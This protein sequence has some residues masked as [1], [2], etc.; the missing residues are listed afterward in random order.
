[1]KRRP[2]GLRDKN[3]VEQPLE[4]T[5]VLA[6]GATAAKT[7]STLSRP[8]YFVPVAKEELDRAAEATG[9][10]ST[11]LQTLTLTAAL[12]LIAAGIWWF[13]QPPTAESL[14]RR[15]S[16]RT[17][18]KAIG[19]LRDA[20]GDIREYLDR[21]PNDAH[22]KELRGYEQEI[23]LDE[24]E[25]DLSRRIRN[26]DV[27]GLAPVLRDYAE[28]RDYDPLHPERGIAKLEA[29][30]NLYEQAG[31]SGPTG[32]C[33]IAARRR[34][35]ELH[36]EVDERAKAQ[37]GPLEE[38]LTSADE[39]RESD[40][41]R[42]RAMYRAVVELYGDKPWAAEPVRR[43]RQALEEKPARTDEKPRE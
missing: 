36:K 26:A 40:P 20:A 34:L 2:R 37:L 3:G 17:A 30:V 42:A 27:A 24:L 6:E 31:D 16:D 10:K 13:L 22:A 32:Q 5:E 41:E 4:A 8:S 29:L 43:A 39:L 9:P 25:R 14:Y 28:A 1:M 38:R 15:I 35:A 23:E 21:F 11:W 19:S 33:L 7:P 18:H 12:V